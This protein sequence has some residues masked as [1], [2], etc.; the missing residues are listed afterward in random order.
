[1]GKFDDDWTRYWP[2]AIALRKSGMLPQKICSLFARRGLGNNKNK[3]RYNSNYNSV[4]NWYRRTFD[5]WPEEK[6]G[7]HPAQ[8]RRK[9][10]RGR[11]QAPPQAAGHPSQAYTKYQRSQNDRQYRIPQAVNGVQRQWSNNSAQYGH[12]S[13]QQPIPKAGMSANIQSPF[14]G[15]QSASHMDM[16]RQR[17]MQNNGN[18]PSGHASSM[19]RALLDQVF[20]PQWLSSD[21][22]TRLSGGNNGISYQSYDLGTRINNYIQPPLLSYEG[23][24][25]QEIHPVT[26]TSAGNDWCHTSKSHDNL[27]VVSSNQRKEIDE[28]FNSRL[29]GQMPMMRAH[30]Q[31]AIA[32]NLSLP[33][34]SQNFD[35]KRMPHFASQ[36]SALS[37]T[38]PFNEMAHNATDSQFFDTMSAQQNSPFNAL[39][40]NPYRNVS[41]CSVPTMSPHQLQRIPNNAMSISTDKSSGAHRQ[42]RVKDRSRDSRVLHQDQDKVSN[43]E[44]VSNSGT[45]NLG[46]SLAHQPLSSLPINS[47]K[48]SSRSNSLDSGYASNFDSEIERSM[49]DSFSSLKLTDGPKVTGINISSPADGYVELVVEWRARARWSHIQRTNSQ[50]DATTA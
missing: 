4:K 15:Y 1:M 49:R 6:D 50:Q 14:N 16:P 28:R 39:Q 3:E 13:L 2:E 34:L 47:T 17:N 35:D 25:G 46:P 7:T 36:P 9:Q 27:H 19:Q 23:Q 24:F 10:K 43:T 33:H 32:P 38:T 30:A 26:E 45:A 11:L 18:I 20:E 5:D 12:V 37:S 31:P 8:G 40:P 41:G 22:T 42:K 44:I 29:G 48:N 21:N